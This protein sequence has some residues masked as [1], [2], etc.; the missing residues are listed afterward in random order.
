MAYVRFTRHLQRFFP[1][2]R[3][4]E[5]EAATVGQLVRALDAMHPGLA[6]YLVDDRGALRPHVNVFVED[7][8]I[9]DRATLSDPLDTRSNVYILQ[10]LS[11]G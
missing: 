4:V 10:A 6:A 1:D 9:R 7:V 11:G 8:L 2:L 5:V 3:E